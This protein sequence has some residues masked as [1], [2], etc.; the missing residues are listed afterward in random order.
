MPFRTHTHRSVGDLR[1]AVCRAPTT[2][3]ELLSAALDLLAARS[4]VPHRNAQVQRVRAFIDAQ[5]WT[6]AALAIAG[7]AHSRAV[8]RLIHEDGEWHCRIGSQ[9]VVPDW[10]DD[11]VEFS[12]PVLSLA[13]L[14]ALIDAVQQVPV[15]VR[16][17][18][19]VPLS[20]PGQVGSIP[21]VSCDNYI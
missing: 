17:A 15:T 3:A 5:A 18:T 14:G 4:A 19:S 8:R 10:V 16:A 13:I 9:W 12:H 11:S 21:A 20:R 6:E 1:D 2:T 7:L